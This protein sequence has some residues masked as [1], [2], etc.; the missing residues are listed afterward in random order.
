MGDTQATNIDYILILCRHKSQ[1]VRK[2]RSH[3]VKRASKPPCC[4]ELNIFSVKKPGKLL[5]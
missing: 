2:N 1:S 4:I 3:E 5:Q